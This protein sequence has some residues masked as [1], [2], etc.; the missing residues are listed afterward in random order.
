MEHMIWT[1]SVD[2]ELMVGKFLGEFGTSNWGLT[3]LQ[4]LEV[5]PRMKSLGVP[6]LGGDVYQMDE[7]GRIL[8]NYDNWYCDRL[9]G[10]NDQSFVERSVRR[11]EEYVS[12]YPIPDTGAIF[13]TVV[14]EV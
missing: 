3:R 7:H 2:K 1:E 10:E 8:P 11:A 9:P 5:L 13:F 12:K 14:P 6:I 4:A